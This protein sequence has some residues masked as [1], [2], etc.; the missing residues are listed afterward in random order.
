MFQASRGINA[1]IS[2]RNLNIRYTTGDGIE[3]DKE[4]MKEAL[5]NPGYEKEGIRLNSIPINGGYASKI[6]VSIELLMKVSM[7]FAKN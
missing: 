7:S 4:E 3:L 6:S 5:E 1:Q 2:D